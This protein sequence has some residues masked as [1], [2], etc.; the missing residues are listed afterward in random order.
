MEGSAANA[1]QAYAGG[2]Y[3]YDER[4]LQFDANSIGID[5]MGKWR[6]TR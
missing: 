3:E 4:E 5:A 6:T 1:K 2:K